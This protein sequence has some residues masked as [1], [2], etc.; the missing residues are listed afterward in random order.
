LIITIIVILLVYC[1][2][3]TDAIIVFHQVRGLLSIVE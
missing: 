1:T 3:C 2:V